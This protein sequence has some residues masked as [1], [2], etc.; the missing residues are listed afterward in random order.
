[1][2]K[3]PWKRTCGW[4]PVAKGGYEVQKDMTDWWL[5]AERWMELSFWNKIPYLSTQFWVSNRQPSWP[6][7]TS[8]QMSWWRWQAHESMNQNS[9]KGS[10]ILI[11]YLTWKKKRCEIS[12]WAWW[13]VGETVG[14]IRKGVFFKC[15]IYFIIAPRQMTDSANSQVR[16]VGRDIGKAWKWN[17]VTPF[18]L[19]SIAVRKDQPDVDCQITNEHGYTNIKGQSIQKQI[20]TN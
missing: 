16:W 1:M 15:T 12:T 11:A 4:G 19:R 5:G 17:G 20:P 9:L 3:V 7:K 10:R 13:I 8:R 18:V 2:A 6:F 14:T